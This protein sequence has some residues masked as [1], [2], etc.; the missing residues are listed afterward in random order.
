MT[1][2]VVYLAGAALVTLV[3]G[4][5]SWR[6]TSSGKVRLNTLVGTAAMGY[7]AMLAAHPAGLPKAAGAAFIVAMLFGGYAIGLV[8]RRTRNPEM[9]EPALFMGA[10]SLLAL[11][12]ALLTYLNMPA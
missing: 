2:L 12:G 6:M 10:V 4:F 9:Q 7:A 11:I 1:F 8:L 3:L 5:Q